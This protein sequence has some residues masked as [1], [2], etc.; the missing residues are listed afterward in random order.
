MAEQG[1]PAGSQHGEQTRCSPAYSATATARGAVIRMLRTDGTR[2]MLTQT[3]MLSTAATISV[4]DVPIA[5]AT[6]RS[7]HSRSG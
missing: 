5:A 2:T 4:S 6:G 3:A 1:D 7:G